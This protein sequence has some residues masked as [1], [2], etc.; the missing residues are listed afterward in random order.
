MYFKAVASVPPVE[1]LAHRALWSFV[2]LAVLVGLRGRWGELWRELRNGKL[3][4]MLTLDSLIAAR[5]SRV[6]VLEPD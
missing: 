4:F 3:L 1:V 6:E 5:E 2:V